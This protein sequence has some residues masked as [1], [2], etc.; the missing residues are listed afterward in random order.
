MDEIITSNRV[1]YI[2]IACSIALF[3]FIL[4]LTRRKKIRDEYSILWF[5]FSIIFIIFS[6]WRKGL[7]FFAL[8]VGINY[9]PSALFLLLVIAI[10]LIL[11]Q[12]SVIIS[13]LTNENKKLSQE[14]GL[15]KFEIE[16]L[17]REK[18]HA[19]RDKK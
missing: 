12:F 19:K 11:I 3:I 2:A 8:L 13:K 14:V 7:E 16:E 15:M 18:I 6:I 1:Q 9:A 10:F 4:E 17:N 5:F